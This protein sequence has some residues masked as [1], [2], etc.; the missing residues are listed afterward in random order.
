MNKEELL[1]IKI[2]GVGDPVDGLVEGKYGPFLC[3]NCEWFGKDICNNPRVNSNP[4]HTDRD[5]EGRVKVDEDDCCNHFWTSGLDPAEYA[6]DQKLDTKSPHGFPAG[7]V[8][9]VESV[10]KRKK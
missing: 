4:A 3:D 8:A 7:V 2:N 9:K 10:I 6:R 5:K 1:Q